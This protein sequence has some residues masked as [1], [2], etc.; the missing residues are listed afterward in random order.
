MLSLSFPRRCNSGDP[1]LLGQQH[2]LQAHVRPAADGDIHAVVEANFRLGHEAAKAASSLLTA[3]GLPK[4]VLP[5]CNGGQLTL[6]REITRV[7]TDINSPADQS[8]NEGVNSSHMFVQLG[9]AASHGRASSL[10]ALPHGR[11]PPPM[12]QYQHR[13]SDQARSARPGTCPRRMPS[14][15]GTCPRRMPSR[16]GTCP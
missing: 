5:V 8:P 13:R 16:P 7:I 14:R 3:L 2:H 11:A 10:S 15:P 9:L 12:L 6:R 4:R 1:H